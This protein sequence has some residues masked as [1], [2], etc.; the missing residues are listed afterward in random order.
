MLRYLTLVGAATAAVAPFLS[1][2][3]ARPEP[4]DGPVIGLAVGVIAVAALG[5]A[6]H[7]A[8][9][10]TAVLGA[11]V[12]L[13]LVLWA[14]VTDVGAGLTGPRLPVLAVG[15]L[16]VAIG[17]G[18]S[19]SWRPRPVGVLAA[20]VAV[21]AAVLAPAGADAVIVESVTRDARDFAPPPVAEELTGRQWAWQPPADVVG[22]VAAGHG[23]V[24][25]VGGGAVVALDGA[26]GDEQWRYTR[27]GAFVGTLAAS[28][29]GKAVV[30][31]F[32]S[33]LATRN[34]LL[35]VLDA[36]TGAV[37]FEKVVPAVV[38]EIEDIAP[39]TTAL[40]LRD[41]DLITAYDLVTGDEKWRWTPPDGCTSPYAR[42]VRGKTTVLAPVEC[43]D[44][45]R[46]VALDEATGVER[47]Q[48]QVGLGKDDRRRLD[49]HLAGTPD[50]AVVSA[51]LISTRALPGSVTSGLFDAETGKLLHRADPRWVVRADRGPRVLLEVQ[52]GAEPR[53]LE[54]LDL[55]AGT[56]RPLDPAACR[57]RTDDV[58]TATT[59][60]RKCADN[61]R[62]VTVVLQGLDGSPAVAVPVRMDGS[63]SVPESF[64]VAAP[65]AVVI[66]RGTS[67][68]TP[69]PVVGLTGGAPA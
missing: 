2:G 59:Y 57:D 9:R 35:V 4:V 10:I 62:E 47:W 15:S 21:A 38:A 32:R 49:V 19:G 50:G 64:L 68:G 11:V 12:A 42:A 31:T 48:H 56:S 28:K 66:A 33:R 43:P 44:A 16:A 39:G 13:G 37:R 29:D 24:V 40:A 53:E 55:A 52:D 51:R 22:V 23:V 17:V 5:F 34:D 14:L 26:D 67:G 25:G 7:R 18:L 20:V 27:H 41:R 60:V 65:G 8:A 69:S 30:A 54:V 61:G 3:A 63:G 1:G 6:R 36:D 45:A 58:T 46:L